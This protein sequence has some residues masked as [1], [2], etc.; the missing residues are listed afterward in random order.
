[1]CVV[2]RKQK[3][4]IIATVLSLFLFMVAFSVLMSVGIGGTGWQFQFAGQSMKVNGKSAPVIVNPIYFDVDGNP[5]FDGYSRSQVN[6]LPGVSVSYDVPGRCNSKGEAIQ[7]DAPPGSGEQYEVQVN[8]TCK[9][10]YTMYYYAFGYVVTT[11]A[12]AYPAANIV[13][14]VYTTY[15]AGTVD[16]ELRFAV[17]LARSIFSNITGYMMDCRIIDQHSNLDGYDLGALAWVLTPAVN[18]IQEKGALVSIENELKA[19]DAYSCTLYQ[20]VILTGGLVQAGLNQVPF[21]VQLQRKLM[22]CI[23]LKQPLT[24]GQGSTQTTTVPPRPTIPLD[25]LT[26]GLLIFGLIVVLVIVIAVLRF[27]PNLLSAVKR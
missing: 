18:P 4:K 10:I 26:L 1:M 17:V 19:Q 23:L 22:M 11:Q 8:S 20:H 16:V 9:E 5:Y 7:W 27:L 3:R 12:K 6:T 2:S 25:A 21:N 13:N 15:E 14:V 24:I